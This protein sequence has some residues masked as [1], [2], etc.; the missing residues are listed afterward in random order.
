MWTS[1]VQVLCGA[2]LPLAHSK[3]RP[4]LTLSHYITVQQAFFNSMDYFTSPELTMYGQFAALCATTNEL[5]KKS[6]RL[7]PLLLSFFGIFF[8]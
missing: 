4:S 2:R 5:K 8:S 1:F 7:L 6:R 3:D